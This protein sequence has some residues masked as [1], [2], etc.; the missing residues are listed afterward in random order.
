VAEPPP[1][2]TPAPGALALVPGL[3]SGAAPL[4]LE[5]IHG[6]SVNDSWRVE[7][8][9]GRFVLRL[10]GAEWRRPGV[11]RARERVLHAAAAQAGLAPRLIA[12]SAALGA[13]VTLFLDGHD[14]SE[15]DFAAPAQLER[16]GERLPVLRL[17]SVFAEKRCLA[18]ARPM[19]CRKQIADNLVLYYFRFLRAR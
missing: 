19:C 1:D 18:P 6:G 2:R 5:R 17:E 3:E 11:D 7:T 8:S 10:D 14:W 4:R 16:L 15:A 9:A 12:H 13:L